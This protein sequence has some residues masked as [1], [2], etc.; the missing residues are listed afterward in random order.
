MIGMA[1]AI[2]YYLENFP[3]MPPPLT[4]A[5][6]DPVQAAAEDGVVAVQTPPTPT[7]S[8][9]LIGIATEAQV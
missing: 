1:E 4:T 6:P 5:N 3:G 2:T 9:D 8:P 7:L